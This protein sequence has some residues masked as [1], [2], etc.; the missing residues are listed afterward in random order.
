MKVVSTSS[1]AVYELFVSLCIRI[2]GREADGTIVFNGLA[3]W[4]LSLL[5]RLHIFMRY[6]WRRIAENG[7]QLG[8]QERDLVL[9]LSW[10][11]E[12]TD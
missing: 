10:S 12:N 9:K 1:Y 8:S 6:N 5:A 11:L 4:I 2:H 3:L 7:P